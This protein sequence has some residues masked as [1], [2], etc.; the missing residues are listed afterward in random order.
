MKHSYDR[1]FTFKINDDRW[2]AYLIT[3]DEAE[4][5]DMKKH[6]NGE[7]FGALTSP[8]DRSLFVVEGFVTKNII[9]HE[10]FHIYV[11]YFHINSANITVDQFEEITAE[12]LEATLDKFIKKR[13]YIFKKFQELEKVGRKQ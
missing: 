13:N 7:G 9:T 11:S 4:E 5:L 2:E 12:F 8:D 6:D 1:S 10:L 3:E